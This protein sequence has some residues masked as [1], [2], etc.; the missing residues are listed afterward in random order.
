MNAS[1][2]GAGGDISLTVNGEGRRI[3]RCATVASLLETLGIDTKGVAVAVDGRVV[4]RSAW[5]NVHLAE[6]AQ[7]EIV[8]AAAGG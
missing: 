7:V 1:D 3:G 6:G 5:D 4:P 2:A 8:T